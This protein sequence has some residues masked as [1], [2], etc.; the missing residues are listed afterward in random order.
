M[1]QTAALFDHVVGPLLKMKWYL[2]TK[3][4]GGFKVDHE[5]ESGWS[6]HG[7]LARFPAAQHTI[8]I[9]CCKPKLIPLLVSV[10]Q[11]AAELSE[12]PEWIDGR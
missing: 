4:L 6:L 5:F 3:R 7:K 12:K 8:R 1:Q 2:E 11:Q 10:A 9:C